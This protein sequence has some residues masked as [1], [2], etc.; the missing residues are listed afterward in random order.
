MK[1]LVPL[2]VS[3]LGNWIADE[4]GRRHVETGKHQVYD[5]GFKFIPRIDVP[6]IVLALSI[7]L[8]ALAFIPDLRTLR[9]AADSVIPAYGSLMML[10]ALVTVATVYP[11]SDKKCDSSTF[12]V[13]E[14]FNGNCWDSP[15]SGHL[16]FTTLLALAL[17]PTI[18]GIAYIALN[19]FLMLASRGHYSSDII[20]GIALAHLAFKP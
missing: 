13:M 15:I 16:L 11:K 6:Q 3:G 17:M 8:P 18:P 14:F 20:I 10:R 4:F 9:A 19:S 12:G 5:L 2:V 7:A 1:G